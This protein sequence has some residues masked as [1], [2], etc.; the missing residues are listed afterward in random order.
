MTESLALVAIGAVL[1]L[2][3]AEVGLDL[4]RGHMPPGV[5]RFVT[6]F[7]EI[8]LDR[9]VLL[10]SAAAALLTALLAGLAPALRATRPDLERAL[11]QGRAGSGGGPG[12][13]RLRGLLIGAEVA[14]ALTLLVAAAL[15]VR[16][17]MRLTE[18]HPGY[19]PHGVL[20][21]EVSLPRDAFAEDQQRLAF[22]EQARERIAQL[23]GVA[24][25]AV[26]T[27]L[28]SSGNLFQPEVEIEG[29][30]I[31]GGGAG[32][33]ALSRVVSPEYFDTLRIPLLAGRGLTPSDRADTVPVAV[34]SASTA[35]RFWPDQDPLGKRLRFGGGNDET[36]WLQV[37]GVVGDVTNA[38]FEGP[39]QPAVYRALAQ[40]PQNVMA[41]AVRAEGAPR[42]LVPQVEDAIRSLAPEQPID[43]VST[44][45]QLI[46]DRSVGLR[47]ASA[48]MGVF[49]AI[50]VVLAA[51]G[52]YGLMSFAVGRRTREL[53]VRV[54]LGA[55]R[56]EVLRS[57]VGGPV[58]VVAV[59]TICGLLLALGA[60][61]WM[62]AVMFGLVVVEPAVFVVLAL[63]LLAVAALAALGPARRALRVDPAIT[64]RA[65]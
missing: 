31:Q 58:A 39:G 42:D 9:R 43:G 20:A 27:A 7:A 21:F 16:G 63:V 65:E 59:G 23:P 1:A 32:T 61:R 55:Q 51:I 24:G 60:A 25:V 62:A 33:T 41:F 29:R 11:R 64:L 50:A 13:Q 19:E 40:R 45:P 48:V 49:G 26:A 56:S 6:G 12:R 52:L 18:R 44:L 3:L 8:D 54:A 53:G 22:F 57:A 14:L 37:V 46:H 17:T 28:P 15:V 38:W 10:V 35:R 30:P 2:P 5:A 34:V 4:L 36:P 47:Y